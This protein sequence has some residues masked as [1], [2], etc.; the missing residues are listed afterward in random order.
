MDELT[1]SRTAS[2]LSIVAGVWLALSPIWIA[3]AGGAIVSLYIVAAAMIIFGLAQLFTESNLPSWII[4]IAAV[5][6]FISAF[7]FTNVSSAV[8]WNEAITAIVAFVLAVW[9]SVEIT[10]YHSHHQARA[11]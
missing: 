2:V 6:L 4:A 9:D 3:I 1:Q 7:S 11:T 10:Q 5:W 8:R